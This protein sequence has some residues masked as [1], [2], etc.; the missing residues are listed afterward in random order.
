[1]DTSSAHI[2]A[3]KNRAPQ[4]VRKADLSNDKYEKAEAI[5]ELSELLLQLRGEFTTEDGS[6]DWT[7]RTYAYRNAVREL[8]SFSGVPRERTIKMQ[9]LTRYHMGNMLRAQLGP[10]EL[11]SLGLLVESPNERSND[12]RRA[13]MDVVRAVRGQDQELEPE[14][15]LHAAEQLL[16][17]L[18]LSIVQ[19]LEPDRVAD[20]QESL[21]E[22]EHQLHRLQ[23]HA[24]RLERRVGSVPEADNT[25]AHFSDK[26]LVDH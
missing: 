18:R 22:I 8:F 19:N 2:E 9:A 24:T 23:R 5:K 25:G 16:R 10:D 1:M 3:M 15:A 20:L 12:K 21:S 14:L 4:L 6:P 13:R 26:E 17:R 11:E 7:G